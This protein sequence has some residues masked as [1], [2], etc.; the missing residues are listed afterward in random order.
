MRSS[1]CRGTGFPR[2]YAA[3]RRAP[4]N[5]SWD[6]GT[7]SNP[8]GWQ[9]STTVPLSSETAGP[10]EREKVDRKERIFLG[11]I[12]L[13]KNLFRRNTTFQEQFSG[14]IT[15]SKNIFLA[16]KTLFKNI[17]DEETPL[18]FLKYRAVN[19]GEIAAVRKRC[20]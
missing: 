10:V 8:R 14:E 3:P 2:G 12:T 6:R 7:A 13:F 11:G 4:G 20:R 19:M 17:K 5:R 18:Q 15:L 1:I 16:G 9:L